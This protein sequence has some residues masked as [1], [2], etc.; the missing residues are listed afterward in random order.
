M[1]EPLQKTPT[2]KCVMVTEPIIED[3]I[4]DFHLKTEDAVDKFYTS[5]T[6]TTL[7]DKS[8]GLY[9]KPWQEIYEMLKRELSE[10]HI[11]E[12]AFQQS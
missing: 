4:T 10:I 3:L 1:I 2:V 9:L 12:I 6:F 5:K 7:A 8:S 11:V